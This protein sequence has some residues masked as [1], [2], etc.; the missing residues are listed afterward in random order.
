MMFSLK[1]DLECALKSTLPTLRKSLD[2]FGLQC[3]LDDA[4]LVELLTGD[5]VHQVTAKL[6]ERAPYPL[7]RHEECT[8]CDALW[9][10]HRDEDD[11]EV[12]RTHCDV[13]LEEWPCPEAGELNQEALESIQT[14]YAELRHLDPEK[15]TLGEYRTLREYHRRLSAENQLPE[16]E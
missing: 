9:G 6:P 10:L 12:W 1:Y 13:C 2:D 14:R 11:D 3:H 16:G 7:D 15:L 5:L 4:S 8:D